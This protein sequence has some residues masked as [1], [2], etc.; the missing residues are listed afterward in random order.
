VVLTQLKTESGIVI[1]TGSNGTIGDAV[2]RRFAGRFD[3]VVGFDRKAPNPPPPGCTAVAV[4]ITSGE[5]VREG[6]FMIREHHGAY[7]ASVIHL[8]AY[9]AL[10]LLG[11]FLSRQMTSFQLQHITSFMVTRRAAD[12]TRPRQRSVRHTNGPCR[13]EVGA[14]RHP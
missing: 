1:A 9:Y 4:D 6:L 10:V 11:F 14:D 13:Y 12:D 3:D 7:V 8:A 5:S 2:M